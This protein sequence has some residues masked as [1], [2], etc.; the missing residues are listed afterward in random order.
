[1]VVANH[2]SEPTLRQWIHLLKTN[3]HFATLYHSERRIERLVNP[4]L[5]GL[6]AFLTKVQGFDSVFEW[7]NQTIWDFA[8]E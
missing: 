7:Q 3:T 1:M 4:S 2:I 8:L 5:S 6:P